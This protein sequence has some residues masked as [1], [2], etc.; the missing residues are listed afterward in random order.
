MRATE[1]IGLNSGFLGMAVN[2]RQ[3]TR[4]L[5]MRREPWD[6]WG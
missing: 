5:P 2:G 3:K 6:V 1:A 4:G